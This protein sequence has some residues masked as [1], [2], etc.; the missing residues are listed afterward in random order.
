[1]C[2]IVFVNK[3]TPQMVDAV[4]FTCWE[5]MDRGTDSFGFTDGETIWKWDK[6]FAACWPRVKEI[7]PTLIGR[8]VICHTR[9]ASVGAVTQPNAHPFRFDREDGSY[10][11]GVHNGGIGNHQ[12]LSKEWGVEFEVDS[13]YALWGVAHGKNTTN[14]EGWGTLVWIDSRLPGIN[15]VR[16]NGGALEVGEPVTED[17]PEHMIFGCST[18]MGL[19]RG[20]ESVGYDAPVMYKSLPYEKLLVA[21]RILTV[22]EDMRFGSRH[23]VVENRSGWC[24]EYGYSSQQSCTTYSDSSVVQ[25][26]QDNKCLLCKTKN[27]PDV[28]CQYCLDIN[29]RELADKKAYM[30]GGIL[31]I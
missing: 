7:L 9:G 11:V 18:L 1:M 15:I 31:Y 4:A 10:V 14:I 19:N 17:H 8:R 3:L 28:I 5:M 23:T 12:K 13:Q 20:F 27:C 2:G 26:Y 22:H 30:T 16:F 29:T 24:N 25:N 21:D 6:S